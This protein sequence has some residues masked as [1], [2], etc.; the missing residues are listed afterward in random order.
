MHVYEISVTTTGAVFKVDGTLAGTIT[1]NIP[2]GALGVYADSYYAGSGNVPAYVDNVMLTLTDG[3]VAGTAPGISA[4]PTNLTISATSNAT[5]SV[6]ATGTAPLSYQW[7][8]DT[9]NIAAGTNATLNLANCTNEPNR[10]LQCSD[11]Q[12][13]GQHHQQCGNA[14]GESAGADDHLRRARK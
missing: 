8:N 12:R 13:L 5:F 14:D 6:T 7:C 11:H 1:Q 10:K 9:G 4:Q 3:A 2:T